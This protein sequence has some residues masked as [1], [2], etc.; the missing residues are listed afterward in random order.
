MKNIN[1]IFESNNDSSLI[2][3][4]LILY[5][6]K[7]GIHIKPENKGKFTRSAKRAGK[8]VQEHARDVLNNPHSTKLQKKRAQFAIN[9]KK[10]HHK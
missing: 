8:S 4:G 3:M 6:K 2:D 9:A 10:W 5:M 7:G 1:D